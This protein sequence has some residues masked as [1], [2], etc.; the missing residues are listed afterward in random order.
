MAP[1]A[2]FSFL[3]GLAAIDG[4]IVLAFGYLG[5]RG[6]APG[7]AVPTGAP[8]HVTVVAPTIVDAG[9][10]PPLWKGV[11]PN[12]LA[13]RVADLYLG[14]RRR[15][16]KGKKVVLAS[17]KRAGDDVEI[18]V[19]LAR[20][21]TFPAG[22][23]CVHCAA[24]RCLFP[25]PT[26]TALDALAAAFDPD[27][28]RE[29]AAKVG[30]EHVQLTFVGGAS[31]GPVVPKADAQVC[32]GLEPRISVRVPPAY[33]LYEVESCG[34][35]SCEL[36]GSGESLTIGAGLIDD[37]KKLA[38]LRALCTA[39]AAHVG[40]VPS[41]VVGELAFEQGGAFRG[42]EVVL[43]LRGIAGPENREAYLAFWSALA[44]SL[45]DVP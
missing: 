43:T 3:A 29:L 7:P 17:P 16:G 15:L 19:S 32:D 14:V 20:A 40:E 30:K 37:N 10:P 13:H 22:L 38:C 34:T 44:Q 36:A 45:G 12:E 11:D 28:V 42:A 31:A 5:V 23:Y 24:Q 9:P 6:S 41:K 4:A 35:R 8:A 2:I 33:D 18:R 21:S 1:R 27:A 39:S 26:A 25:E